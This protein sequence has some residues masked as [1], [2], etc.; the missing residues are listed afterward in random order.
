MP[1]ENEDLEK[2][3]DK[4]TNYIRPRKNKRVARHRF[5]LR[6]QAADESF[7]HF[8]K[9]LRI[10]LLNCEYAD[11]DDMLIDAIISGVREKKV[12]ERL[13]DR[14]EDLTLAKALE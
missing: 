12:Q 10:R 13:V 2:V 8:V 5:K 7:D 4:F 6:K 1:A 14:R 11:G 9:D 3:L